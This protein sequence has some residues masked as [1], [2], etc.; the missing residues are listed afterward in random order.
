MATKYT[1][2]IINDFGN[3]INIS[4]FDKEVR[5]EPTI[6][7]A[8]FTRIET[9]GDEVYVWFDGPITSGEQIILAN[10][11]ANHDSTP[12]FVIDCIMQVKILQQKTTNTIYTAVGNIIYPGASIMS[13]IRKIK[14]ISY[15]DSDVTS[16]DLICRDLTA[17]Q[18]IAEI[19]FNNTGIQINDWGALSN[20]PST[21]SIIE[22]SA[23]KTGGGAD[24]AIYVNNVSLYY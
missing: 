18:T 22:I 7:T 2:S 6:T 19:T 16:Y 23:R 24:S 10:I 14:S 8:T 20:V 12:S 3:H 5:N 1:Y 15:M 21:E 4:N 13:S 17:N 9:L 11:I